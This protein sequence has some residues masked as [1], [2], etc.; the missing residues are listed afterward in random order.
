M[1]TEKKLKVFLV[2][3]DT[4]LLNMYSLKFGKNGFE[5]TTSQGGADALKKLKDGYVPDVVLL[6]IIMPGMDGIAL[7][8]E[9]RAEKLI[10]NASLIMLTNQS[11]TGD[12]EHT[13]ELGIDG[14][15]VKATS[16]PSE[17]IDD[18]IEIYNKKKKVV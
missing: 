6:D 8:T 5:V 2:D 10:P 12:I 15:I 18:V 14:Y 7:L 13:K 11:D 4:F 1:E 9:I 17:V 3:D 16:I